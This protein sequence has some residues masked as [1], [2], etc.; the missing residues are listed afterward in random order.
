M[1]KF[2]TSLSFV[3][4]ILIFILVACEEPDTTPPTVAVTYPANET[5]VAEEVVVTCV[6]TDNVGIDHVELWVDGVAT[7]LLDD[8][9]PFS[10]SW[11]T[12]PYVDGSYHVLTV[13]AYDTADN[14]ADSAPITAVVD[15]TEAYPDS[16]YIYPIEMGEDSY[17]IS[18]SENRNSDFAGYTLYE[19][20]E[21]D[22]SNST[23]LHSLSDASDTSYTISSLVE[24]EY[25]YY[26]VETQ[27]QWGLTSLSNIQVYYKASYL[28]SASFTN[29]W[30]CEECGEGF[31]FISDSNGALLAQA[32][33]TGNAS[34]EI[35][36][37][38]GLAPIPS[39]I[40]VTTAAIDQYGRMVLRTNL[41]IPT[42]SA[43]TFKG[44]SMS[45]SSIG[46]VEIEFQN[47]PEGEGYTLSSPR[48]SRSSTGSLYSPM[49]LG[50]YEDPSS[51]YLKVNNAFSDP[52]YIFVDDVSVGSRVVDLSNMSAT[53]TQV[54]DLQG[55]ASGTRVWLYGYP[56]AGSHY[57]ERYLL[58][59][60]RFLNDPMASVVVS[61]PPGM[62]SDF[63]T[64][65]YA[66]D[67]DNGDYYYY[68]SVYGDIPSSISKL[69]S[70]FD[71][72]STTPDD[73][74]INPTNLNFD[75]IGS[76]WVTAGYS[77]YWYV[78]SPVNVTHYSLPTLPS[79]L[80]QANPTLESE[81][82][83]L[84][85]GDLMEYPE[86][87]GYEEV[88]DLLYNSSDYFYNVVSEYQ[89]RIKY[90]SPDTATQKTLEGNIDRER[91]YENLRLRY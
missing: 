83:Y 88:I 24:D 3:F 60:V 84:N 5:T 25:R 17:T 85:W 31:I 1:A 86:L 78:Y 32:S 19:S 73:F 81:S 12:T 43:W 91:E 23:V 63:R 71:F 55:L 58:D 15:Q 76:V 44:T 87:E 18:W 49:S 57:A 68:N 82:F 45:G 6:A 54:L 61:F 16:A 36:A 20:L 65:M 62:F 30:L 67:Y 11:N 80:T 72:V 37:P 77:H 14:I 89:A 2:F 7:S 35:E 29:D 70:D 42:G 4:M 9:E 52:T 33:W 21:P 69:D 8:S 27:D 51:I 40:T 34:F 38:E 48:S 53:G 64:S 74:Q 47:I 66:Y 39:H 56:I 10:F 79:A 90:Y 50:L 22:M 26:Q 28:F 46:D 75:Q 13:R 41:R 59:Y